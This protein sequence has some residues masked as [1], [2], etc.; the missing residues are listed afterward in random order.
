MNEHTTEKAE[1]GPERPEDAVYVPGTDGWWIPVEGNAEIWRMAEP[2][3]DTCHHPVHAFN[4]ERRQHVI[5]ASEVAPEHAW[6]AVL[7]GTALSRYRPFRFCA[8]C[9]REESARGVMRP[10][11]PGHTCS[12]DAE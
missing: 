5:D 12:G 3:D 8:R 4:P 10:S 1:S 2:C 11:R 7:E 6:I 9:D